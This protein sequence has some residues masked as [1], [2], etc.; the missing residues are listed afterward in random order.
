[1]E[2]SLVQGITVG[3]TGGAIAGAMVYIVQQV[4]NE[5]IKG[6]HTRRLE[7]WLKANTSNEA[8]NRYRSTKAIASHNNLTLDR[9][10]YICSHS[11][12]IYL[13][14]GKEDDKWSVYNDDGKRGVA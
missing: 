11:K 9:V 7:K 10:R 13:S 6:T 5:L 12:H 4:H 3:A 14:T 8:G 2:C 1:M